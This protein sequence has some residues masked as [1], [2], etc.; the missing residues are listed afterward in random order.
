[1]FYNTPNCRPAI[2]QD[3][4]PVGFSYERTLLPQVEPEWKANAFK[5]LDEI[6]DLPE[7]WD[8]YGS[9]AINSALISRMASLVKVIPDCDLPRCLPSPIISPASDGIQIEWNGGH[10]GVEIILHPDGTG[11]LVVEFDGEYK[12]ST[13]NPN[14]SFVVVSMLCKVFDE[15]NAEYQSSSDNFRDNTSVV[16]Q[17]VSFAAA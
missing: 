12:D 10:G 2:V 1:M 4:L 6:K 9:P 11:V 14:D 7:N 5:R 17:L 16:S 13:L 8:G 3:A 15:S